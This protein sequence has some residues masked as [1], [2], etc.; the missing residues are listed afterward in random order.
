M[1]VAWY[2][3]KE[4]REPDILARHLPHCSIPK[5]LQAEI[6][7]APPSDPAR[8]RGSGLIVINPPWLL[9]DELATLLPQFAQMFGGV[10]R[11][12]WLTPKE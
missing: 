7:F 3:I 9:A 6:D 5:V 8:L 12:Q 1:F 10:S 4:R 11:L 2:P